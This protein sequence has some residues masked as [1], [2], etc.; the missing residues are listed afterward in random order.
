MRFGGCFLLL[1]PFLPYAKIFTFSIHYLLSSVFHLLFYYLYMSLFC[2]LGTFLFYD[3]HMLFMF[4]YSDLFYFRI[5]TFIFFL[6]LSCLC[7][8][9]SFWRAQVVEMLGQQKPNDFLLLFSKTAQTRF[10]ALFNVFNLLPSR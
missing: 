9:E 8:M 5:H 1:T 2:L 6:G 4:Y 7:A 3:P 10:V